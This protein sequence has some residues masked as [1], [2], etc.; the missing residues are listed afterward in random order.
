[1]SCLLLSC[2]P[3]PENSEAVP[4][5]ESLAP[6]VES[7]G[8]RFQALAYMDSQLSQAA[9]GLD[10]RNAGLLPVRISIDNQNGSAVKIIPRQTFLVD[11]EAQAWPLLPAELAFSR[12]QQAGIESHATLSIPKMEEMQSHTGFA[13]DLVGSTVFSAN[14]KSNATSDPRIG[15]HLLEKN[16]SNPNVPSGTVA[17]GV[18]I[19]P[20]REEAKSASSLRLCFEQ[21]GRTKFIILPLANLSSKTPHS[22]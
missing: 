3:N 6:S 22:K 8:T 15:K 10:M 5:P 18:L 17:S 1:M 19:F 14:A 16:L 4:L 12:L 7:D 20:G 13:M 11:L 9:T 21:E 2:N